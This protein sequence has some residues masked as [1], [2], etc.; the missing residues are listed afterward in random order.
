M[1]R[2]IIS[3]ALIVLS[4]IICVI[5]NIYLSSVLD[6]LISD[7]SGIQSDYEQHRESAAETAHN[8]RE[9]WENDRKLLSVFINH[10]TLDNI[11]E[12][13][14]TLECSLEYDGFEFKNAANKLII[15]AENIRDTEKIGIIG[16]L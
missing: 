8:C 1:K 6:S 15:L 3:A 13:L 14:E 5:E 2:L 11:S 16:L 7:V 4:L 10:I 9:K 12:E